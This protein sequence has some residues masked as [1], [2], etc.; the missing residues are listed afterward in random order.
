MNK[1]TALLAL[2]LS[3]VFLTACGN[4]NQKKSDGSEFN[5]DEVTRLENEVKR[6]HDDEL[7][8]KM[9]DIQL[10]MKSLEERMQAQEAGYTEGY[11]KELEAA[12]EGLEQSYNEMMQWMEK[13]NPT[14]YKDKAQLKLYLVDERGKLWKMREGFAENISYAQST[15]ENP[16]YE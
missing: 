13:Y 10:M 15:L 1:I 2:T 11:K 5:P 7:M 3:F 6:I 14:P 9:K 8:P 16:K 12:H 4:E